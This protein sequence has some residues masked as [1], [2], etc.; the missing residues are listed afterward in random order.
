MILDAE[1]RQSI[2]DWRKERDYLNALEDAGEGV[3]ND[4]FF[5]SDDWAVE[6]LYELSEA[7]KRE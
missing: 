2:L 1:T 5:D 4:A 6:I 7:L 3:P